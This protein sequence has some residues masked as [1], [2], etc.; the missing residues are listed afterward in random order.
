MKNRKGLARDVFDTFGSHSGL[1][2]DVTD[3]DCWA[4]NGVYPDCWFFWWLF[5][6]VLLRPSFS[7]VG[8]LYSV[9]IIGTSN[10]SSLIDG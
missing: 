6:V 1:V 9:R 3:A 7:G 5:L 10:T 8:V 2:H 4:Q